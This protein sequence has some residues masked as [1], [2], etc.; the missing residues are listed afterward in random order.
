MVKGIA[1]ICLGATDLA[2]AERFYCGGLG[3][4]KRFDFIR[5]DKLVGFYL[6]AGNNTFIEIFAADSI[7][8]GGNAL[9]HICLE[10]DN[11]DAMI[12]RVKSH[13]IALTSEKKL[14]ADQ[15]W[16]V[17]IKAPDGVAIEFHQYTPQSSQLTGKPCIVNW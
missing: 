7:P 9:R 3:M 10:T 11:I 17:W 14:G 4:T 2:A 12:E 15:S 16:Q 13:G 8:P 1:H 6:Y 5:Q